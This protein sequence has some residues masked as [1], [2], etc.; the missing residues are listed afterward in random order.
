MSQVDDLFKHGPAGRR[1]ALEIARQV[2]AKADELRC[3]EGE[4]TQELPRQKLSQLIDTRA[5]AVPPPHAKGKGRGGKGKGRAGGK[6]NTKQGMQP[7]SLLSPKP[8]GGTR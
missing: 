2:R 1:K 8:E 5:P 3:G 4:P 6:P 7:A